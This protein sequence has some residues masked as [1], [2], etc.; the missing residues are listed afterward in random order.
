VVETFLV[1]ITIFFRT[2]QASGHLI[3][4]DDF[5]VPHTLLTYHV[6]DKITCRS[7]MD[8]F[9]L[10]VP[11]MLIR[12]LSALN[13]VILQDLL[14]HQLDVTPLQTKSADFDIILVETLIAFEASLPSLVL[15]SLL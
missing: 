11:I 1:L 6:K 7:V 13:G 14:F 9:I 15:F 10:L 12:Y 8:T 2:G 3:A 5:S 4:G